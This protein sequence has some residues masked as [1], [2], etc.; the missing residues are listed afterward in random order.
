[1]PIDDICQAYLRMSKDWPLLR[2]LR[3]GTLA[4]REAGEKWLPRKEAESITRYQMRL[5][6]SSLFECYHDSVQR[7]AGKP[8]SKPVSFVDLPDSL[9]VFQADADGDRTT[10]TDLSMRL[11]DDLVD[12]GVAHIIVDFSATGG[13]QTIRDEKQGKARP[14]F[15]RIHP[16][17][18]KWWNSD[19]TEIRIHGD[20]FI[21]VFTPGQK[22]R[23][24]KKGDAWVSIGVFPMT[25][26]FVPLVT[27]YANKR[28]TLEPLQPPMRGL[29]WANLQHYQS[30]ADQQVVLEAA[31]VPI[32]SG[33]GL[34]EEQVESKTIIGAGA[35][36]KST[37]DSA[38]WTY[39]EHSGAAIKA[40]A[41]DIKTI[42]ER[43]EV[44]GMLPMVARSG[45][46][47][48]TAK[49]IDSANAD[50]DLQYWITQIEGGLK[51][52]FKIAAM[53]T[54]QELPDSFAVQIYRDFALTN[55]AGADLTA[56]RNARVDGDLTRQTYLHELRR[57]GVISDAVDIQS[58]VDLLEAEGPRE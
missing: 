2:D 34:S 38:K 54:S 43:M 21:D 24:E 45:A 53:W 13:S 57:R 52:A 41:E 32:L 5:A 12:R 30:L 40:G 51:D 22:E 6:K 25:I 44:L 33:T 31:R 47:T 3:G 14:F 58:E 8:F 56:L 55:K 18:L 28:G 42:E 23:F 16:E 26:G 4:M 35:T 11:L 7:I 1:M 50:T 19:G 48:A 46:G 20:G 36:F 9:K 49:A 37:N 10:I 15:A 27:I 29:A 39:V 17:N